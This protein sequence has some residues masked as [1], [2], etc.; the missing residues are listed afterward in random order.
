VNKVRKTM[1][2]VPVNI[3][4]KILSKH[5][6]GVITNIRVIKWAGLVVTYVVGCVEYRVEISRHKFV[7]GYF[8]LEI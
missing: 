7:N 5:G 2:G 3:G 6:M 8:T 4:D 1:E